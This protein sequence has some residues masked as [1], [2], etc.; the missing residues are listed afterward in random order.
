MLV[1]SRK[2]GEQVIIAGSIRVT[3]CRV[4]GN[5][6][7]L[8]F[9]APKSVHIVRAEL[10]PL[11]V[12]ERGPRAAGASGDTMVGGATPRTGKT[13]VERAPTHH[14]LTCP[15][16]REVETLEETATAIRAGVTDE[17]LRRP[18]RHVPR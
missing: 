6:V 3:V 4:E 7:R 2:V 18:P 12:A 1:L 11:G 16:C 10:K 8:G 14:E 17:S 9:E 15:E 5:Q 13:L